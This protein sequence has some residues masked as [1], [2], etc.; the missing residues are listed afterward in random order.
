MTKFDGTL[1][2]NGIQCVVKLNHNSPDKECKSPPLDVKIVTLN[3]KNFWVQS[4][5]DKML[6]YSS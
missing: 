5:L 3:G 1:F 2:Y 4:K 6:Q